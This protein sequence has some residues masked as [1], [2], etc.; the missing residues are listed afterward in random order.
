MS[1]FLTSRQIAALNQLQTTVLAPHA[2]GSLEEWTH[3]VLHD[4]ENLVDGNAVAVQLRWRADALP[5][6][7]ALMQQLQLTR[8]E[9]EVTRLLA[10]G[11][12]ND[13]IA[14]E[15][16]IS[17]HTV[18]HHCEWVFLKL[19]VHT[20]KALALEIGRRLGRDW[21]VHPIPGS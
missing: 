9:A 14:H 16:G 7:S 12:S 1:L 18:R 6:V 20:R 10:L 5:D 19:G 2:Y 15:L 11:F 13:G 4:L 3:H 8:R 21:D 17:R